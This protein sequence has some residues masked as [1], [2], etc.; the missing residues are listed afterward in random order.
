VNVFRPDEPVENEE[1]RKAIINEF[2]K[3][4]ADA[5]EVPGVFN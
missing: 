1:I 3:K 2:P 5:L 4:A